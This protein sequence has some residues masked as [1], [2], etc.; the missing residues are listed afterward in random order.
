MGD[1][2]EAQGPLGETAQPFEAIDRI[3]ILRRSSVDKDVSR[4]ASA[5]VNSTPPLS[6]DENTRS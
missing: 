3:A 1:F 4:D 5:L 6:L 2:S